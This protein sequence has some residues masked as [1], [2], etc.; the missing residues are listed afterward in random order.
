NCRITWTD[1]V[2]KNS[3]GTNGATSSH[4]GAT[5]STLI[6]EN[7][8]WDLAT[9]SLGRAYNNNI[10]TSSFSKCSFKNCLGGVNN[11]TALGSIFNSCSFFNCAFALTGANNSFEFL[12][13]TF[14]KMP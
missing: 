5:T 4:S 8:E 7:C 9:Y 10:A 1:V 3:G 14:T 6:F 11:G 2:F 13:C 12:A